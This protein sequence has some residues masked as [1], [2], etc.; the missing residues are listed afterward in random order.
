MRG[1]TLSRKVIMKGCTGVDIF[2]SM[3]SEIFF[4][5][6]P[7]AKNV[8]R[9]WWWASKFGAIFSTSGKW[10]TIDHLAL[11]RKH[12]PAYVITL[13][14]KSAEDALRV[15]WLVSMYLNLP[16]GNNPYKRTATNWVRGTGGLSPVHFPAQSH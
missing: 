16:Y 14:I 9:L 13:E 10:K 8:A 1:M 15:L 3:C 2:V 7:V 11:H 6:L 4:F 5:I 12:Y